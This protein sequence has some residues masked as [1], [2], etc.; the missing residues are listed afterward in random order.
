MIPPPSA[1]ITTGITHILFSALR[2]LNLNTTCLYFVRFLSRLVTMFFSCGHAISQIHK[3]FF[4]LSSN[5]RSGLLDVVVS[6]KLKSKSY[7][8]FSWSFSRAYPLHH[9]CLYHFMS[10]STKLDFFAHEIANII[11]ALLCL[12][13]Y[14]LFA[15]TLHPA[16]RYFTVFLCWPHSLHLLHSASPLETFHDFVSTICSSIFITEAVFLVL[17]FVSAINYS[18]HPVFEI[19][20]FAFVYPGILLSVSAQRF[21]LTLPL[22]LSILVSS[23]FQYFIHPV[24]CNLLQNLTPPPLHALM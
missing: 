2:S 19:S 21:S 8:S 14:L 13:R 18:F 16:K 12:V 7:T 9:F 11:S 17:D 10:F 5:V 1:P 22:L 20:R 24:R 23:L 3:I 15:N 4:P 6:L